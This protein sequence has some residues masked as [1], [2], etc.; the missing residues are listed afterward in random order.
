[1]FWGLS[2]FVEWLSDMSMS[3]FAQAFV[4]PVSTAILFLYVYIYFSLF[5]SESFN[6]GFEEMRGRLN[7]FVHESVF[8]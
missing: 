8:P 7:I 2:S 4:S 1:M 6:E 3:L 5:Y